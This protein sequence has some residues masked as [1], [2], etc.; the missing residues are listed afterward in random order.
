MRTDTVLPLAA[1][2]LAM[3]LTVTASN[4]LV[5]HLINDWLTWGAI[6]Y[7]LSFLI[8]DLTTRLGGPR[9]A[10]LVVYVGFAVA[11]LLSIGL[12]TP[13]IALASGTAFLAGQ[14]FDIFVFQKLRHG[15]WWRAPLVGSAAGS[16]L[17][18]T[19]F[20]TLAFAGTGLPVLTLALGDLAVKLAMA[21]L[22]LAPFRAAIALALPLRLGRLG[23]RG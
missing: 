12:A 6:T 19:L 16:A 8:T 2:I 14:L 20:I 21:L 10:R 23:A 1:A 13:R 15:S 5:Q 4:I 11:V 18:T 22:F 9:R 7:P 3:I 17:D